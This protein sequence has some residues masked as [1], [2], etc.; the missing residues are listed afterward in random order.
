MV[1]L[2]VRFANLLVVS[3]VAGVVFGTWLANN[4]FDLSA[5]TYIE[6][7]QQVIRA[8]N[9]LMPILG[10]IGILLTIASA[11]LARDSRPT[12]YLLIAAIFCL[13]VA[14]LV[15]NF[16]NQPINSQVMTWNAQAPPSNWMELRN[17]WWQWHT[18]RM[19]AAILA[20]SFLILAT[21]VKRDVVK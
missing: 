18:I 14:G 20:L 17:E 6:Q 4:P 19:I 16:F 21:V 9:T 15:T 10:A 12:L 1:K 5:A 11:V 7:Q 13:V 3:L 8:L 2:I